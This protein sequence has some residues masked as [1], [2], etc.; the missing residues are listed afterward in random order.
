MAAADMTKPALLVTGG[1]GYIGSHVCKAVA[2]AGFLP[3]TY[4]NLC[5]GHPWAVRWGPLETGELADGARLDAVMRK[6]RPAAVI[7]LAGLIAVGESVTDPALYYAN[8]VSGSI[9]LLDAMRRNGV[10]RIVFSSTAAVYGEPEEAM[11]MP[12]SHPQRPLNPYG[13]SKLMIERVLQDYARA[14]G[15]RSVSLR[16]FNAAGADPDTEIG[17]AHPVETH[18][19]PLILDVAAGRRHHI[20]IYGD[21][22]ATHDGTCLRDYIHVADLADAHVLALKYLDNSVGAHAF[23]LGNGAGTTVKE[24]IE[25]VRR[26]TGAPIPVRVEARRPGDPAVLLADSDRARRIL[27]WQPRHSAV[28]TMVASA[29][30]WHQRVP[31]GRQVVV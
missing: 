29:W 11:P 7:H 30:A 31:T 14:Y 27:V 18:L 28:E 3:V 15:L 6:Y 25:T 9:S 13:T 23:N 20:A 26:V 1:A 16:Y 12:E 5:S 24:V 22:Y 2:A 21:D 4:D 8:N 10:D 17:E 19:I